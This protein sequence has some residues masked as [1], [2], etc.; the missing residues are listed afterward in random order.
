[1]FS[2][3]AMLLYH[4]RVI[5]SI[6]NF[7]VRK[8]DTRKKDIKSLP[9][10]MS[11][12]TSPIQSDTSPKVAAPR[13]SK[14][15]SPGSD[16]DAFSDVESICS[17]ISNV[18]G[19]TGIESGISLQREFIGKHPQLVSKVV[20]TRRMCSFCNIAFMKMEHYK[21][22]VLACHTQQ[23]KSLQ[24]KC[25]MCQKP[26]GSQVEWRRHL[27]GH[28]PSRSNSGLGKSGMLTAQEKEVLREVARRESDQEIKLMYIK[29]PRDLP[30]K[31]VSPKP[32]GKL[33]GP[34]G[35]WDRVFGSGSAADVPEKVG[36]TYTRTSTAE[37]T[38]KIIILQSV[39]N[40]GVSPPGAKQI[41]VKNPGV[42]PPSAKQIT[43]K[44]PG[45][46]PPST[47]QI[48]VKNPGVSPP[49][50]KQITVK[51]PDV[52]PPSAKK[53][54]VKNPD[55]S[56]PGAKQTTMATAIHPGKPNPSKK[57]VVKQVAK[58]VGIYCN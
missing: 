21:R 58:A 34:S 3:H 12:E 56:P 23:Q 6:A 9:N 2:E 17:D 14:I 50:A 49:S 33:P 32:K 20:N 31:S 22:H 13:E 55:V 38:R 25:G 30:A 36:K 8:K 40:P 42:S 52:S 41:T 35:R 26:F 16:A 47:K 48:T 43:V 11:S 27:R 57:P 15:C 5:H 18:T 53:I 24:W 10:I 7:D 45:V 4:M 37:S 39:K 1:M 44:N 51:N 46:S 28:F 19:I 29:T 54:T